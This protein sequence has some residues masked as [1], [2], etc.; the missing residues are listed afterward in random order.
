MDFQGGS[1]QKNG[2]F[3]K[4]PMGWF[5]VDLTGNTGVDQLQKI[6][7]LNRGWGCQFFAKGK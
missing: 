4:I 3:Q 2:K 7:I 1:I 6:D 5:T